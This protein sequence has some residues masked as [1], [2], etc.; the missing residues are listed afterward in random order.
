MQQV[1]PL[2]HDI[3]YSV[4]RYFVDEF[5]F[6]NI[7]EFPQGSRIL[8]IGGKKKNKRGQFDIEKYG[9]RVEY[10]NIDKTTE[11]DFLC[12]I[13]N[14]PVPDASFDGII[15]SEVFEHTKNPVLILREAFRLL[16]PDGRIII[17][18]PF[19]IQ[20]HAD[21]G[22]Y[23]RYT[24]QYWRINLKEVGFRD[25]EI[26]S[27]GLF[28]SVIAEMLRCWVQN[29]GLKR[30]FALWRWFLKKLT[31]H[32]RKRAF[33]WEMRKR[34]QGDIFYQSYT[35]GYGIIARK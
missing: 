18:A 22:D 7:S 28:F 11:P 25:I 24:H 12:D 2:I 33:D 8:D 4:R 35:T 13:S 26:E 20:Y 34:V 10:A 6:R 1:D 21:P 5:F 31:V 9:L 19:L 15:C 23:G 32:L 16:K 17:T 30:R 29:V 14:I 3:N 27:Q